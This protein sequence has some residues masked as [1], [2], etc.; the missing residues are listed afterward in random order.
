MCVVWGWVSHRASAVLRNETAVDAVELFDRASLKECEK[1][2][3]MVKLVSVTSH[4]W[5]HT[6]TRSRERRPHHGGCKGVC[7]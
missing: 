5:T 7:R 4:T 2:E 1:D 6:G 3:N